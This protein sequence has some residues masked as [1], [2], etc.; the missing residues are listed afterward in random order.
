VL[1][2]DTCSISIGNWSI[3]I[4]K[5]K[6]SHAFRAVV[7]NR[8]VGFVDQPLLLQTWRRR[9]HASDKKRKGST[10]SVP[11]RWRPGAELTRS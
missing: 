10:R 6:V 4:G 7:Y 1:R 8:V 5:G 3:E 9:L 2:K 11:G